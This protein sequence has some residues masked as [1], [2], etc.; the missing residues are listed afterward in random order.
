MSYRE[1]A[2]TVTLDELGHHKESKKYT[3]PAYG[4]VSLSRCTG[5]SVQLFGSHVKHDNFIKLQI[6]TAERSSEGNYEFIFGKKTLTEVWI[7]GTQLGDLLSSMNC[8]DGVP[9]TIRKRETDYDIPFIKDDQTPI[10]ESRKAMQDRIN[11]VTAAARDMVIKS[12]EL[13]KQK[14][15]NKSE[16]KEL[17]SYLYKIKQELDSNLGFVAKCF[18]EKMEKTITHAKGEVD[19]FVSNVIASAGLEAIAQGRFKELAVTENIIT[20]EN[21]NETSKE[22]S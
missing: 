8:G 14:T 11:E 15:V 10:S 12:Q 18:D 5:G 1:E 22:N 4:K 7:S 20:I 9:C 3:H 17:D 2:P 16:L 19:A 13:L 21:K 6:M